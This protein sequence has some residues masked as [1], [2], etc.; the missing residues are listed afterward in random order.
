MS[1]IYYFK[2]LCLYIS[3]GGHYGIGSNVKEQS[4]LEP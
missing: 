3:V 2:L 4:G 1:V